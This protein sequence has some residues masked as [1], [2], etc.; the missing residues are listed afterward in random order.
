MKHPVR[1]VI[2]SHSIE[3]VA[4][5]ARQRDRRRRHERGAFQA[6]Q[7]LLANPA[8][9]LPEGSLFH[10]HGQGTDRREQLVALACD[11]AERVLREIAQRYDR[12]AP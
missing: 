11:L 9:S 7:G 6:L 8:I 10:Q 5:G 12:P 2:E 1:P 3:A 4:H